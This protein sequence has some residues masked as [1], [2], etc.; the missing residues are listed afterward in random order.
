MFLGYGRLSQMVCG[1]T[2]EIYADVLY[3]MHGRFVRD[4]PR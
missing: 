2:M 3:D 4:I 1:N